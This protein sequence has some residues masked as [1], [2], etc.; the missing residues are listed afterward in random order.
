MN[1]SLPEVA[2]EVSSEPGSSF[3]S[4][5]GEGWR[6]HRRAS[7]LLKMRLPEYRVGEAEKDWLMGSQD[8]WG[9]QGWRDSVLE[10]DFYIFQDHP[11]EIWIETETTWLSLGNYTGTQHF[12]GISLLVCTWHEEKGIHQGLINSKKFLGR[13]QILYISAQQE[14][15]LYSH[16]REEE[17]G[18]HNRRTG[19]DETQQPLVLLC[20]LLPFLSSILWTWMSNQDHEGFSLS[21][22]VELVSRPPPSPT[23]NIHTHTH[24]PPVSLSQ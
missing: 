15:Y 23:P 9:Q 16:D 20:P 1:S 22:I 24:N 2:M 19:T 18:S 7:E 11:V 6:R 10:K 12:P 5:N 8:Q 21:L 14:N 13:F 17:G 4:V 3:L